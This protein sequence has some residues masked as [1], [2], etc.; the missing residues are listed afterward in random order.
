MNAHVDLSSIHKLLVDEIHFF[1]RNLRLQWLSWNIA[2]E[3][4]LLREIDINQIRFET[5]E[6]NIFN[7]LAF[8]WNGNESIEPK[9]HSML[10]FKY[11]LGCRHL[12]TVHSGQG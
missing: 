1:I 9:T 12:C 11:I 8:N 7:L 3:M 6:P 4:K 10:I 5:Q 2:A